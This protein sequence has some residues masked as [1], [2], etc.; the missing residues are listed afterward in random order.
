MMRLRILRWEIVLD[1]IVEFNHGVVR[2]IWRQEMRINRRR[3]DVRRMRLE[4]EAR[5]ARDL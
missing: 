1:D 4:C 3:Y 5:N 2:I